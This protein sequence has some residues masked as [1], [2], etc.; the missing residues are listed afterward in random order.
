MTRRFPPLA[1][2]HPLIGDVCPACGMAFAAGD[3]TTLT[4][5]GPG[6]DPDARAKA[7]AGHAYT[8]VALPI[9]WACATGHEEEG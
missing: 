4:A 5:L 2:D 7:R 3:V 9:H 8:A 1:A 6:A